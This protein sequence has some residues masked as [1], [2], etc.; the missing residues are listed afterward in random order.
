MEIKPGN[1]IPKSVENKWRES[2]L[3]AHTIPLYEANQSLATTKINVHY[4][5]KV[6]TITYVLRLFICVFVKF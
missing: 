2:P 4:M 5:L 1:Q 6:Y 3:R